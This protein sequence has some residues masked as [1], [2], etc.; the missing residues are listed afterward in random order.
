MKTVLVLTLKFLCH[1][2]NL[3][4]LCALVQ[5]EYLVVCKPLLMLIYKSTVK[6][7]FIGQLTREASAP[8][9]HSIISGFKLLNIRGDLFVFL[10]RFLKHEVE[11]SG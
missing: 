6:K 10:A 3:Y 4:V 9:V 1:V 5:S 7:T 11:Q 8:L 2:R